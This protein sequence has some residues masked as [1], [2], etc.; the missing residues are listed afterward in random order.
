M[1]ALDGV[2]VVD[3]T[4]FIAGPFCTVLLADM[5]ADVVKIESAEGDPVRGQGVTNAEGYSCYFAQFN[6]NKRS[7]VLDLYSDAGKERLRNLLDEAAGEGV[8]RYGLHAQDTALLTCVVPSVLT[9]DHMHFIDGA[10]GG[11]ALAA[12]QLRASP[13]PNLAATPVS[14]SG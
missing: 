12:R 3:L 7:V 1:G 9:S 11:Y 10:D 4:R 14:A 6:R 2:R 8:L 5:G 13:D